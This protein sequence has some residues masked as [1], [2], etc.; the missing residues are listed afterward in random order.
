MYGKVFMYLLNREILLIM[1]C[2]VNGVCVFRVELLN[3]F[4]EV[5]GD[6]ERGIDG[7]YCFNFVLDCL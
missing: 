7:F 3:W 2:C 6:I 1:M 4:E 5:L